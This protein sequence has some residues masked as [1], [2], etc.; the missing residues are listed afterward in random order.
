MS[1]HLL[2]SYSC[3]C[4]HKCIGFQKLINKLEMCREQNDLAFMISLLLQLNNKQCH[5]Q[6]K[7]D[8]S[9]RN[10]RPK[11]STKTY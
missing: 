2:T 7:Q 1:K 10:I 8:Q 6:S 3:K 11:S 9:A 5:I 4:D